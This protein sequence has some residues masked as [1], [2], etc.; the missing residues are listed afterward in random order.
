MTI[1]GIDDTDSRTRGMCTTYVGNVIANRLDDSGHEVQ[2]VLLV[3]LNPSVKHKTRGNAAVAIHTSAPVDTA[4]ETA[5]EYVKEVAETDDE[6]T[7]PGVVVLEGDAVAQPVQKFSKT[8]IR[9]ILT[10]EEAERLIEEYDMRSFHLG[11]GRGRIG[12]LAA[13]GACEAFNDWTYEHISYREPDKWGTKRQINADSMFEKAKDFYPKAWDTVD[14]VEGETVAAP[15]TP[16]PILYGIRGDD[17]TA[18]TQLSKEIESESIYDSRTFHTNQGTD[19]HLKENQINQLNEDKGYIVHGE[20]TSE[21]ETKQ[22]GHVFFEVT[23]ETGTTQCAAF[24]PTKRF[25]DVVRN[26]REGDTIRVCGEYQRDT[27]KLEKLEITHLNTTREVN[28]MCPCCGRNMGSAG[29]NQGYRCKDCNQHRDSKDTVEV[30]R[31][32]ELGWYEVPPCA[33]RHIAKPL[34]RGGFDSE[35]HPFR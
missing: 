19:M 9:E 26:L 3:R 11:K 15:H 17:R 14:S 30:E 13:I 16:C 21:P 29:A 8:A 34:I 22:G 18:V 24:E 4:L 7:H 27:I 28:P 6:K 31:D 35:T 23:D 20:V 1:I 12:S 32:V 10:I 5:S 25:R 33:R 2:Q